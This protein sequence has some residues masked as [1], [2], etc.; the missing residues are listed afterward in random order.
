[1]NQTTTLT[2]DDI[3]KNPEYG[4]QL[5]CQDDWK[6]HLGSL[7]SSR[8]AC[9]SMLRSW[10]HEKHSAEETERIL[11]P[12]YDKVSKVEA[13]TSI[14]E[15]RALFG[16]WLRQQSISEPLASMASWSETQSADFLLRFKCFQGEL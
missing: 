14:Y 6:D 15:S 11:G 10:L 1:M 16:W 4:V 12:L 5:L 8:A 9:L 13:F 7:V 3:A 2:I